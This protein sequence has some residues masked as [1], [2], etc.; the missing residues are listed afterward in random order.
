MAFAVHGQLG[1]SHMALRLG[2]EC[3]RF[4][5]V[6][7]FQ[8]IQNDSMAKL[9]MQ[10]HQKRERKKKMRLLLHLCQKPRQYL[11]KCMLGKRDLPQ[12]V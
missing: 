10:Y 3:R 9:N 12:K 2:L 1:R 7:C 4:R 8:S 11:Y 5:F 6:L